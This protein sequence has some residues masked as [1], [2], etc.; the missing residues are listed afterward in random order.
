VKP[1]KTKFDN[2]ELRITTNRQSSQVRQV[3]KAEAAGFLMNKQLL[4][5]FFG[6]LGGV[7]DLKSAQTAS[8]HYF[9][10]TGFV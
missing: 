7:N 6:G 9:E 5:G 8:R 1:L 3:L 4:A 10:V 2:Q